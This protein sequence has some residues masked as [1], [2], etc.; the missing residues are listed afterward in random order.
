MDHFPLDS[1]TKA[2]QYFVQSRD[3][4]IDLHNRT[5]KITLT[6]TSEANLLA[7]YNKS[8]VRYFE[9]FLHIAWSVTGRELRRVCEKLVSAG[10]FL[11]RVYGVS[12]CVASQGPIG[13]IRN[14]TSIVILF[15][16]PRPAESYVFIT[17][18]GQLTAREYAERG[19]VSKRA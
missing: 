13:L 7:S 3:G 9:V 15:D 19:Q 5:I 1:E 14:T 12:S 11:L 18:D 10:F 16:Y 2:L 17:M 4:T 6:S 8:K